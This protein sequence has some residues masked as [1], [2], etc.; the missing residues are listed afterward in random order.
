MQIQCQSHIICLS[1]CCGGRPDSPLCRVLAVQ[2]PPGVREVRHPS[3]GPPPVPPC[4]EMAGW[5]R[6]HG[7]GSA[8]SPP[9]GSPPACREGLPWAARAYRAVKG[10]PQ[11]V[12]MGKLPHPWVHLQHRPPELHHGHAHKAKRRPAAGRPDGSW[13][14]HKADAAGGRSPRNR[15]LPAAAGGRRHT[16]RL[17]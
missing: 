13:S 11:Q 4:R 3:Q 12:L 8:S 17:L 10:L 7:K 16:S 6:H 14:P 15:I 1:G 9:L 2:G 5:P